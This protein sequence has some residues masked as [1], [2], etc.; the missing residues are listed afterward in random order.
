MKGGPEALLDRWIAGAYDE[1]DSDALLRARIL[2]WFLVVGI[3]TAPIPTSQHLRLGEYDHVIP[4]AA[5]WLSLIVILVTIRHGLSVPTAGLLFGFAATLSFSAS[6]FVFGGLNSPPLLAMLLVPV[7]T[8]FITGARYGWICSPIIAGVYI[9]LALTSPGDS[10]EVTVKLT[11]LLTALTLMTV[12][13]VIF[14]VQRGRAQER[15]QEALADAKE[16]RRLAEAAQ[17]RAEAT[18]EE[19]RA[20]RLQ[21]ERASAAKTDFL[22]NMSHEIRTPMNAVIGMTGLL[23][24]TELTHEQQ[25]LTE[26]VRSSSETLLAL[27]NDILDFSKIEAGELLI[28]RAPMSIRECVENAIEVV[29]IAAVKKGIEL[30]AMIDKA[31]PLA[32]H[33]DS[34]RVQQTLV[35]LL[36]N[37]IKFTSEGEVVVRVVARQIED[38]ATQEIHCSI[39][40]TGIGIA[41]DKIGGLFEAFVQE[42]VSTTR[43]F[44]GS[45]LGLTISRRL[46]EA[47]GGRIWIESEVGVGSTFHFTLTG[48]LAP[49]I[50]PL[51]LSDE[52]PQLTHARILVV[53]DNRTNRQILKMQLESW[54]VQP[55]IVDS[56]E[57]ALAV[58]EGG[59]Q[60]DLAIYDMHMPG[61]DGLELARRTRALGTG[62]KLPLVM[63]TSLGQR[64]ESPGMSEFA[65]FLT[66]PVKPS[67]LY[68]ALLSLISG[69]S[70]QARSRLPPDR[71]DSGRAEAVQAEIRILLAEDNSINQ[72]VAMMSLKRLGYRATLVSDGHEAV[73]AMAEVSYDLVLMDVHMPN[74]DGLAA[75]RLIRANTG[76]RQP[77]IAAL[78]ANATVQDRTRCAEAG[79]DDYLSKPFRLGDLGKLMQRYRQWA[80]EQRGEEAIITA[81]SEDPR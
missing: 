21:A 62:A 77:Y 11:G 73:S 40:D 5:L 2:V 24:E 51:Y 43:R 57:A 32:I 17:R 48:P 52:Q 74:L 8:I 9:A 29:A 39:S 35:N 33:G 59:N 34:T 44:G 71:A 15:L 22:A 64:N 41:A 19:T 72:R 60:F 80:E 81:S 27:I 53:D 26:I 36:G 46:V 47:M 68:N 13:I 49:F 78:T 16:A 38:G 3:I 75:T 10:A 14:E 20:A 45:G 42:D 69:D 76:I 25:G 63:L 66:K 6:A 37:A 23:L 50:R 61:M 54:G 58:L 70:G 79:M 1:A 30:S 67:R 31:V 65:V 28:E 56:G 12:T 4:L 55:T 18:E 7:L